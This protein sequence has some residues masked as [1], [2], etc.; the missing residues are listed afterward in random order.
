MMKFVIAIVIFIVAVTIDEIFFDKPNPCD[1]CIY[2]HCVSN[3]HP[4]ICD[5][6][7]DGSNHKCEIP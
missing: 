3:Q 1:N 7:E 5:E 6:C 2:R 4:T